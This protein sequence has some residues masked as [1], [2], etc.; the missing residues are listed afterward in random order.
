MLLAV[1]SA[2]SWF[3]ESESEQIE[4]WFEEVVGLTEERKIRHKVKRES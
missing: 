3:T 2:S 4:A 1:A